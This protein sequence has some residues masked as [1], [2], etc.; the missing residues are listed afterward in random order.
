MR[1]V[2]A[3]LVAVLLT[4]TVAAQDLRG[5]GG[6]VRALASDGARLVS[7]GLDTRVILW[8]VDVPGQVVRGH[9]G[10]VT[11][12]LPLTDGFAS[13]GQDGAVILWGA[14][15]EPVAER[16]AHDAPVSA[17][18][19]LDGRLASAGWDGRIVLGDGT[20]IAAHQGQVTGLV[21]TTEGFA[22]T[23]TDLAL[24]WWQDARLVAVQE[25]E[26]VPAALVSEGDSVIVAGADGTI[27][28]VAPTGVVLTRYL[29]DRPLPVVALARGAGLVVAASVSGEVWVLDGA[30]LDTRAL[31]EAGQGAVW[32]VAVRDGAGGPEVLTGGNDGLIRRW[33]P[34]GAA[35]GSGTVGAVADDGSRGAEVW[36]ACAVCHSLSPDD[37]GRAGPTLHGVL[38]RRIGT[39]LGYAYSPALLALDIVWTAETISALF[40]L[41]PEAYTPGSRMPEQRLGDPEDRAALVEYLRANGG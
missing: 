15:P 39:A 2:P 19:M 32:A 1:L 11:A 34:D 35:L 33:T 10:A 23:G 18:A 6:P 28:R 4:G 8:D 16:A 41:G 37:E 17:L 26:A 31:I 9:V 13:G 25:F 24:R 20:T 21:A 5:H 38:G 12:V 14:G 36:R 22:S 27:T 29:S 30:T 40:E 3:A 7:G